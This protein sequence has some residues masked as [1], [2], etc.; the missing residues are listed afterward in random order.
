MPNAANTTS[1][2]K[3]VEQALAA[4]SRGDI[5]SK[6]SALVAG[7]ADDVTLPGGDRGF[8]LT[9]GERGE[10]SVSACGCIWSGGSGCGSAPIL[11]AGELM[12][13]REAFGV[14]GLTISTRGGCEQKRSEGL[15]ILRTANINQLH[16]HTV[17]WNS[18]W[19]SA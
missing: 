3:A 16:R 7:A 2:M 4:P 15:T 12:G 8:D 6:I 14:L 10:R 9:R 17:S 13:V 19:A 18:P 1:Q 5:Q 11:L